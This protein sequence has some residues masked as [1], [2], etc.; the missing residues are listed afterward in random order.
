[1]IGALYLGIGY[2]LIGQFEEAESL[3]KEFV[4]FSQ[5]MGCEI[6]EGAAHSFLGVISMVKGQMSQGLEMLEKASEM[7][8]DYE[9]QLFY[10]NSQHALGEAYLQI[11]KRAAPMSFS[12]IAKNIGFLVKNVPFASKKAEEHFSR[13]IE[14][15]EEIGAKGMLGRA[16]LGLGL[17]HKATKKRNQARDCISRASQLFEECE[18]EGPL[19]QAKEALASL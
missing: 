6:M 9:S 8:L 13:A 10:A 4:T 16:Y 1:M 15:A 5:Q 7:Y 19:N 17:L 2:V 18:A 3:L 14:V 11:V 12:T